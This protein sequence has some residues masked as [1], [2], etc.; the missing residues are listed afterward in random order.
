MN[1]CTHETRAF[2]NII[3]H[4]MVLSGNF[5]VNIRK[6]FSPKWDQ[7]FIYYSHHAMLPFKNSL[8][9]YEPDNDLSLKL[10]SLHSTIQNCDFD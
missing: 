2:K 10:L 5:I 8:L 6:L 9:I 7:N 1:I 4:Q 3:A